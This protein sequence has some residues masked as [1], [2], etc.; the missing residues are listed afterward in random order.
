MQKYFFIKMDGRFIKVFYQD[1]LYVE[2]SRNYSKIITETKQYLVLLTMKRLEE[3]LPA[4]LF[5]RIHKSFIV[6]LEKIAEFDKETVK[7]KNAELPIGHHYRSELEKVVPIIS[8]TNVSKK[9]VKPY[10]VMPLSFK[11]NHNERLI[12][13]G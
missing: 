12:V 2:G 10:Y 6:S 7:L 8:D 3:F 4:S 9:L 11:E 5:K 1:I 13:A